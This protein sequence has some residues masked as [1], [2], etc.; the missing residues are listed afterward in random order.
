MSTRSVIRVIAGSEMRVCQYV[1]SDGYPTWRGREVLQFTRDLLANTQTDQLR[2]RVLASESTV[3]SA[4]GVPRAD[5][6]VSAATKKIPNCTCTGAP[7][8]KIRDALLSTVHEERSVKV[9]RRGSDGVEYDAYDVKTWYET[10]ERML[11]EG[12]LTLKEANWLAVAGR[13]SGIGA[14]HWLMNHGPISFYL[15]VD[16]V[17]IQNGGG[18]TPSGDGIL[19][20]YT[21]DLDRRAVF[22]GYSGV[23]R[24]YSFDTVAEMT[25]DNIA[26]EMERLEADAAGDNT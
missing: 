2:D 13:D 9:T 15:P 5:F 22:C 26:A 20:V 24:E 16:L 14:L 11:A 23:V 6:L 18:R 21:I 1:Q 25:D 7:T 17:A 8:T 3:V 10:L 19:G 12:D 4:S